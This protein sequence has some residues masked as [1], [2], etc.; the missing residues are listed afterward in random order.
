MSR[1]QLVYAQVYRLSEMFSSQM[2]RGVA[3]QYLA[4]R[5]HMSSMR[6]FQHVLGVRGW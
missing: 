6:G 3:I 2:A 1:L 5:F 4:G